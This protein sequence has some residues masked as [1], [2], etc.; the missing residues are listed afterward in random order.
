VRYYLRANTRQIVNFIFPVAGF[1][2]CL[3][4][5]WNLS[6]RAHIFGLAWMSLGIAYAA[7]TTR[8]FHKSLVAFEGAAEAA[9]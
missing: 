3:I 1:M 8:G 5:W 7:W 9:D 6:T 2:V 4:L